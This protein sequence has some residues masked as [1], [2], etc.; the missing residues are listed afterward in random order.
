M[1]A[2]I[3]VV[4]SLLVGPA[5]PVAG[6]DGEADRTA[7]FSACVGPAAES[8]G[9]RD[10][11]GSFAEDAANCLAHYE[12]T[13]G[14][15]PGVY[16]PSQPVPR[17]QMALFLARAALPAGIVLP[18]ATDQGFTDLLVGS[19]TRDAINQLAALEIM[20][21]TS[22]TTFEPQALV[23]RQQMAVLL[24]R[25][26]SVAPTGPGGADI[27]R[28]KPDDDNFEDL[29]NVLIGTY[30]DIRKLFEMGVTKGTSTSRFS[31]KANVSR[32]Q[33]A[34]F[35]ARMLAHTNARPAGLIVQ[36]EVTEVFKGSEVDVSISLRDSQRQPVEEK[37]VDIFTASDL[38]K[39]FDKEGRCTKHVVPVSGGQVCVVDGGD[40]T[41]DSMGNVAIV[42][43]VGEVDAVRVWAWTGPEDTV[44]DEDTTT[45]A[46]V[47]ITTLSAAVALEVS[48]DMR[49]TAKQ[50][51]FGDTVTFTFQLVDDDGDPVRKAGH[52]FSINVAESRDNG[53][54]FDRSTIS[55]EDRC[56]RRIPG[57]L[58]APGSKRRAG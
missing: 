12:I 7:A 38:T 48:D 14:T 32:A 8:A 58:P 36:A 21:G 55:K 52:A 33:M 35:I 46:I 4:S 5:N 54:T 13:L 2:F 30:G 22:T 9:F 50:L 3:L 42:A 15:D 41:T 31:P 24:T 34:G 39:A 56:R 45:A 44:F 27:D 49:P 18:K 29:D 47:D 10:M 11:V 28:V 16:T 1:P 40:D 57:D 51:Q 43:D 53:R 25:F 6:I 19:H 20:E 23:S 37:E 17:W 26:L